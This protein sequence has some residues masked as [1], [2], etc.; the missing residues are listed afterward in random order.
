MK[1]TNKASAKMWREK[2]TEGALKDKHLLCYFKLQMEWHKIRSAGTPLTNNHFISLQSVVWTHLVRGCCRPQFRPH[3]R[4]W[5]LKFWRQ[6]GNMVK[7][8]K[9]TFLCKPVTSF[10]YPRQMNY[11]VFPFRNDKIRLSLLHTFILN[12]YSFTF[13]WHFK[14][15]QRPQKWFED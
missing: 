2:E 7:Y 1:N 5:F 14:Q 4:G 6:T 12:M 3:G 9:K 15:I 8:S 10:Q 11:F 13:L